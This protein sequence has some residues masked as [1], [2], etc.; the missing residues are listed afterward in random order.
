MLKDRKTEDQIKYIL[1]RR[2]HV[3]LSCQISNSEET[4]E[5]GAQERI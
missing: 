3:F 5:E 2:I 1:S 4:H